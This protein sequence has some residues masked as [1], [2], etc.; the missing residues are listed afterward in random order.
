MISSYLQEI[1]NTINKI[2]KKEIENI[3]NQTIVFSEKPEILFYSKGKIM[4]SGYLEIKNRHFYFE[5]RIY[6]SLKENKF[7]V[8]IKIGKMI[9][10]KKLDLVI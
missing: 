7:E 8:T 10:T 9:T 1:E 2:G 4:I 3:L 6:K 5:I